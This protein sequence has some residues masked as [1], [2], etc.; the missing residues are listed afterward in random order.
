MLP[1]RTQSFPRLFF[2]SFVWRTGEKKKS[3]SSPVWCCRF[4]RSSPLSFFFLCWWKAV[5]VRL[6]PRRITKE[7]AGMSYQ[8]NGGDLVRRGPWCPCEA[9]ENKRRSHQRARRRSN[10][11]ATCDKLVHY[12]LYQVRSSFR[13]SSGG[14]KLLCSKWNLLF[15]LLL[16]TPLVICS[17]PP[18]A[19]AAAV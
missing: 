9:D 6:A 18:S 2:F 5:H 17:A 4:D 11:T 10:I 12:W 13:F 1:Q 8:Y 15:S 7:S 14:C 3:S 19:S 16:R